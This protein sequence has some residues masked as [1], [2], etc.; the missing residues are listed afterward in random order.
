AGEK[1]L[2]R[3]LKAALKPVPERLDLSQ[4]DRLARCFARLKRRTLNDLN[5]ARAS[6]FLC[7]PKERYQRKGTPTE[8]PSGQAMAGAA[9]TGPS[10]RDVLSRWD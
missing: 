4:V 5:R 2:Q 3:F 8:A 1:G 10:Q 7:L 6:T 9:L